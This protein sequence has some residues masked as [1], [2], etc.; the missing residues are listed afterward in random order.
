MNLKRL[1]K[2]REK[3]KE[4]QMQSILASSARHRS[5]QTTTDL[6]TLLLLKPKLKET[7]FKKHPQVAKGDLESQIEGKRLI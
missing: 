6:F 7:S 3:E 5:E 1:R 4:K 2:K